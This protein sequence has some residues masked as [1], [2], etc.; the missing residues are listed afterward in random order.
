MMQLA[1]VAGA[2]S[3]G[4][5]PA[6]DGDVAAHLRSGRQFEAAPDDDELVAHAPVDAH[7]P[8]HSEHGLG[9]VFAFGN[10]DGL[11]QGQPRAGAAVDAFGL[12]QRWSVERDRRRWCRRRDW[13]DRRGRRDSGAWRGSGRRRDR[14]GCE[15]ATQR[16]VVVDL[17]APFL[18]RAREREAVLERHDREARRPLVP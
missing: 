13:C 11:A 16:G 18:A 12:C 17:H 1:G 7:R 8:A 9:H 6:H 2:R 10:D 4:D 14:R 3:D 5:L 15:Q